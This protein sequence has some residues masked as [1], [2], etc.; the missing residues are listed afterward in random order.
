MANQK[1]TK[2]RELSEGLK[3]YN[4]VRSALSTSFKKLYKEQPGAIPVRKG[5]YKEVL[6]NI[7]SNAKEENIQTDD[8]ELYTKKQIVEIFQQV[9]PEILEIPTPTPIPVGPKT[10]GDY[11][12]PEIP[13]G[14]YETFY[15]LEQGIMRFIGR[16]SEGYADPNDRIK[17]IH[18]DISDAGSDFDMSLEEYE[19]DKVLV[20]SEARE[21]VDNGYGVYV[22]SRDANNDLVIVL[23]EDE[24]QFEIAK[25]RDAIEEEEK[26]EEPINLEDLIEQKAKQQIEE[27]RKT[28]PKPKTAKEKQIDLEKAKAE[29]VQAIM[30]AISQQERLLEKGL[31]TEAEARKQIKILNQKLTE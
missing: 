20:L 30:D 29:K 13:S 11:T 10:I 21:I 9:D 2:K 14:H 16:D 19:D 1:K 12:Y 4:K 23:D 31:I 18:S 5:I 24:E 6:D 27:R 26:E 25:L 17:I 28:K 15:T 7:W 8:L 3:R 22:F